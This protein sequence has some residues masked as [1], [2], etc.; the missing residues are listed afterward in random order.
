MS[1]PAI[2]I[3]KRL[4]L[5]NSTS[6][7]LA[8]LTNVGVL[9]WLQQHLLARI[10]P[11]EYALYPVVMAPFVLVPL[12]I[13]ILTGGLGRFLVEAYA[14]GDR[15]RITEIV[16]TIFP[17][18]VLAGLAIVLFAALL[19]WQVDRVLTIPTDRV[20]DARWMLM[21]PAVAVAFRVSSTAFALGII[22]RQRF[23][24]DSAIRLAT[25]LG[26]LGGLLCLFW[27]GGT[28]I[29][30]VVVSATVVDTCIEVVRILI[31]RRL[32]PELIFRRA[33]IQRRIAAQVT[34][35]G[36]WAFVEQLANVLR[37]GANPIILNRLASPLDV[38]CFYLGSLVLY[39]IQAFTQLA[40]GTL[41]PALVAMVTRGNRSGIRQL[42]L[43]AGRY[44]MWI[45]LLVACPLIIFRVELVTLYV[46]ERY[47]DAATVMALL[48][49]LLP[50]TYANLLMNHIAH[51]QGNIRATALLS[52]TVQV[53]ALVLTLYLV[54]QLGMGSVGSA[55]AAIVVAGSLEPLLG[56]R[57]GRRIAGVSLLDWLR[58]SVVPGVLPGLAGAAAWHSLRAVATPATWGELA[59]CGV[60]GTLAY[61]AILL[62]FCLRQEDRDD[63]R[64]LRRWAWARTAL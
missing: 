2:P 31:S 16:S 12:F 5:I 34:S 36:R 39:Q 19:A 60:G 43:R 21:L 33:H 14:S 38:S 62:I 58:E 45:A 52:L 55:L 46:G 28:R 50:I 63:L 27:L 11:E 64:S 51:A 13:M 59:L 48:I 53:I 24:L 61:L 29:L 30:W 7:V 47:L 17:L 9:I 8:E 1:A 25:Q 41:M 57:L 22:V 15:R 32:V 54:G 10:D 44:G 23:V 40:A 4:V 35:F 42:Y 18:L 20:S 37:T 26:R 3:S 56:W 49:L 6:R